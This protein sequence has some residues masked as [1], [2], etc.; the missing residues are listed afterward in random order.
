MSAHFV[1]HRLRLSQSSWVLFLMLVSSVGTLSAQNCEAIVLPFLDNDASRLVDYP[2]EKLA[3]RC[4]FSRHSFSLA[5]TVPAAAPLHDISEVT[6]RFTGNPFPSDLAV[7]LDE[8]SYYR[9][10]FNRFQGLHPDLPVYFR[11]PASDRPYL[12]LVPIREAIR[13]AQEQTSGIGY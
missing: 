5:D 7:N 10:D 9:Y 2:A 1:N 4:A 8:L 11:T 12:V 13:K 6:D 3:W